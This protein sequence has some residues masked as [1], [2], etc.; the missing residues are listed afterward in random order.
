MNQVMTVRRGQTDRYRSLEETFGR[1]PIGATIAWDRRD[2]DRRARGHSIDD[3]RRRRERRGP[4]PSTWNA[5]DFLVVGTGQ[6]ERPD[7]ASPSSAPPAAARPVDGDILIRRE[8]GPRG[9]CTVSRVPG[10]ADGFYGDYDNAV[11]QAEAMAKQ[12]GVDVWYTEDHRTFKTLRAYR[13]A[14]RRA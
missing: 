7:V 2:H 11:Q 5:L 1:D 4:L 8:V 10:A 13:D 3:E 6:V 12:A 9:P 14:S